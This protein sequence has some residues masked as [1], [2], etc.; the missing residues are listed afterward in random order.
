MNIGRRLREIRIKRGYTQKQLGA[1]CEIDEA[2]IRKYE[3]LKQNPT[4][5]TLI[6]VEWDF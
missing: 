4:L 5:N 2:N 1:L 3:T 6:K